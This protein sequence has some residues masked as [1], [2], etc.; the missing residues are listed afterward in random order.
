MT[1]VE[2]IKV[3]NGDSV[4]ISRSENITLELSIV[5][6]LKIGQ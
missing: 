5:T 2:L 3:A 6:C 1:R 4:P